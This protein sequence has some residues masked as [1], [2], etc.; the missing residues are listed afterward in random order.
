[1]WRAYKFHVKKIN[2][3]IKNSMGKTIKYREID[4]TKIEHMIVVYYRWLGFKVKEGWFGTDTW[5]EINF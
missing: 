2:K 3:L 5:I 1:M 4:N